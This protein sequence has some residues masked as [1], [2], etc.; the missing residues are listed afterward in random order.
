MDP[1]F[2]GE[3]E[4]TEIA[5]RPTVRP[6]VDPS[7]PTPDYHRRVSPASSSETQYGAVLDM[8]R[9]LNIEINLIT[10]DKDKITTVCEKLL[11]DNKDRDRAMCDLTGLV[12]RSLDPPS[13]HLP[14]PDAFQPHPIICLDNNG[15]LRATDI[16]ITWAG[17]DTFLHGIKV[18]G[19]DVAGQPT[20]P[21]PATSTPYQPVR[22][23]GG[24]N[25]STP[26]Q[27]PTLPTCLEIPNTCAPL[28][29]HPRRTDLCRVG[30]PQS[31]PVRSWLA[32][33]LWGA[34]WIPNLKSISGWSSELKR[35]GSY[36]LW[37]RSARILP[38]S[39]FPRTFIDQLNRSLLSRRIA[40][41]GT[42]SLWRIDLSGPATVAQILQGHLRYSRCSLWP[43]RWAT[44]C[45][46]LHAGWITHANHLDL[47]ESP[48]PLV[49]DTVHHSSPVV[50]FLGS[51][52]SV[53]VN[54][55]I[56]RLVTQSQTLLFRTN[57]LVG[58]NMQSD[59]Q[60]HQNIAPP[61]GNS[62]IPVWMQY[63]RA[64]F[65]L[66]PLIRHFVIQPGTRIS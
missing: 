66:H 39:A 9:K 51:Y 38:V 8:I 50:T 43:G 20:R 36:K 14:Q 29:Q 52:A 41:R 64:P 18:V 44:R 21:R 56:L 1:V 40:S 34:S 49:K 17:S 60:K 58:W 3:E 57:R 27:P 37:L 46:Q 59:N 65:H 32:N 53:A 16:D 6:E 61:Q 11:Y 7:P 31:S 12:K 28:R 19:P 48:S 25:M 42:C 33:S 55:D 10:L 30:Y 23:H 35:T 24:C 63:I 4:D 5:F 62:R 54:S 47:R 22:D 26:R 13:G 15:N 45:G 2:S